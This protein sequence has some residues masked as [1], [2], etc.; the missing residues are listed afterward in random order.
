MNVVRL[1]DIAGLFPAIHFAPENVPFILNNR[2]TRHPPV[3]T[4]RVKDRRRLPLRK[5]DS[6]PQILAGQDISL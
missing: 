6:C 2:R 3:R 1:V 5:I 4:L